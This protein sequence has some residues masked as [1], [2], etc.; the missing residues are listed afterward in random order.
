MRLPPPP[1]SPDRILLSSP[2]ADSVIDPHV[3][4]GF[5]LKSH[6]VPRVLHNPANTSGSVG[7]PRRLTELSSGSRVGMTLYLER[8]PDGVISQHGLQ[9]QP[10]SLP[11]VPPLPLIRSEG[12]V[13]QE[14]DQVRVSPQRRGS[15]VVGGPAVNESSERPIGQ[16]MD[17]SPTEDPVTVVLPQPQEQPSQVPRRSQRIQLRVQLALPSPT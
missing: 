8:S 5:P 15:G 9:P 2:I 16:D 11:S 4:I 1:L 14:E 10:P 17:G 3:V 7:P 6:R 13:G 12:T